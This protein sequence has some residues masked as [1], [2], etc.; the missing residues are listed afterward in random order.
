MRPTGL[1]DGKGPK[2]DLFF[3]TFCLLSAVVAV[4]VAIRI[5]SFFSVIIVVC[6]ILL[7]VLM[8]LD[9]DNLLG[10]WNFVNFVN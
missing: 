9:I 6:V 7:G 5:S 1:N 10:I 3:D 4:D 8:E 2:V